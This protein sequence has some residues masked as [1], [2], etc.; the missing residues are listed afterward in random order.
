MLLTRHVNQTAVMVVVWHQ[1]EVDHVGRSTY[2][3]T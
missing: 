3:T 2:E 1:G